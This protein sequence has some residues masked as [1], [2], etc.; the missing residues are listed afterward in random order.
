VCHATHNVEHS[1]VAQRVV[2]NID[3]V[4]NAA[5]KHIRGTL[6]QCP[7]KQA[8][9]R[10]EGGIPVYSRVPE[11][12]IKSLGLLLKWIIRAIQPTT[13]QSRFPFN[14]KRCIYWRDRHFHYEA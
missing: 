11:I 8:I 9:T 3:R 12:V 4:D 14:F 10:T 7:S 13:K 2:V 1:I 6:Y 5:K